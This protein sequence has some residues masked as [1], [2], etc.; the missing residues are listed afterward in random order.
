[1]LADWIAAEKENERTFEEVKL[2]WLGYKKSPGDTDYS[3]LSRLKA[4]MAN[5]ESQA[6][7]K[8]L[9]LIWLK[10]AASI[11]VVTAGIWWIYPALRSAQ[12]RNTMLSETTISGEKKK[13][14]LDDGTKIILG[15]QS[16]LTFPRSFEKDHRTVTLD[17]EA[18]FEVTKNPHS[19]FTVKTNSI[20]VKVLGTH[21]NLNA[22][23]SQVLNSVALL[24]GKVQVKL[25]EE[26]DEEYL[27][28][29][30]QQ[31]SVNRLTH[32]IFQRP[33]DSAS[34][35]G[36]LKNILIFKDEPLGNVAPAIEKMYG[37]KIIFTDQD[38]ADT[39]IYAKFNNEPLKQVMETICASGILDYHQ[40][41]NKIYITL[42]TKKKKMK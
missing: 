21:F 40:E 1:M 32:Q 7:V 17:G 31:L 30:G 38:T 22:G 9:K 34:V 8:K 25:T 20:T 3:A 12:M 39:R 14:T 4:G 41:G 42:K 37:V 29:P 27:L 36:W 23:H 13:I 6:P 5:S 18:Y 10:V 16:A 35:L 24:E 33:L 15:P 26:S 11:F 2:I 19:P 28:K